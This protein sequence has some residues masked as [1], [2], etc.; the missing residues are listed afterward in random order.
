MAEKVG[1]LYVD[2]QVRMEDTGKAVSA[3]NRAFGR[4]AKSSLSLRPRID[5]GALAEI[6]KA[7]SQMTK[8]L[9]RS[10]DQLGKIRAWQ[11]MEK[12][13]TSALKSTEGEVKRLDAAIMDAA[14]TSRTGAKYIAALGKGTPEQMAAAQAAYDRYI[15]RSRL[16]SRNVTRSRVSVQ[17][18]RRWLLGLRRSWRLSPP[19]TRLSRLP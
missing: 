4:L 17:H 2:L 9:Q 18:R 19:A 16:L 1:D 14:K 6:G 12:N 10:F 5:K 13:A 8:G 11:V 7:G 3:L 15:S